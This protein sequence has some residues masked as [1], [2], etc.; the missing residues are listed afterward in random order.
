M[1]L[2]FASMKGDVNIF[3]NLFFSLAKHYG[4]AQDDTT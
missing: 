2:L 3:L 4:L 1:I